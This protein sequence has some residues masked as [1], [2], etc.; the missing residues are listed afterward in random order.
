MS[1]IAI[2]V[3]TTRPGR[4]S[5]TVAH[6]V[7]EALDRHAAVAEGRASIDLLD[8]A[9]FGLPLLDEPMPAIF[10]DY[11][12]EHTRKWAGAV[13]A[14]DGFVVVTPEYNH[15]M[16]GA[17]KNALD[18]LYAEWAHKAVGFVSYGLNGGLRAVEHLRLVMTELKV[19]SVPSQVALSVFQDFEFA[20]RSNPTDPGVLRPGEHQERALAEMMD[21][22][23]ALSTALKPLRHPPVGL[24][25]NAP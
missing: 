12:H 7:K 13:A 8:F 15:S 17:L 9:D 6:W 14:C 20:D 18:F 24:E 5:L 25:A 19:A 22:V 21:E 1:R 10:G 16:P 4:R 3:G 23:V 2:I 11:S